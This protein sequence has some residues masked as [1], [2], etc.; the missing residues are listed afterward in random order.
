MFSRGTN[1]ECVTNNI[2]T[3]WT[4]L[5]QWLRCNGRQ[6][7]NTE[8]GGGN[9]ASCQTFLCQQVQAQAQNSDGE[10]AMYLY[11]RTLSDSNL[12]S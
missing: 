2:D 11:L 3:A 4:P 7:F 5:S 12:Y 8:T 1:A 6:A 10:R 9:V